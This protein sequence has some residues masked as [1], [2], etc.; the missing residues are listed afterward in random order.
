MLLRIA[1]KHSSKTRHHSVH[2]QSACCDL[3]KELCHLHIH[4][5]VSGYFNEPETTV[6]QFQSFISVSLHE[7]EYAYNETEI[8]LLF[9][10]HCRCLSGFNDFSMGSTCWR[11]MV[12]L[13]LSLRTLLQIT[14]IVVKPTESRQAVMCLW[15]M[16][17]CIMGFSVMYLYYSR[18]F[19]YQK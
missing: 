17:P 9:Q 16:K 6:T 15:Q 11:L 1:D 7:C 2:A 3:L 10:F 12:T 13:S 18:T 19:S 4:R 8:K 14:F 5:I